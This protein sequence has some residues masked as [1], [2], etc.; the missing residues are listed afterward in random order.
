[1]Q[2]DYVILGAL[3][4]GRY[5]G[6][7]LRRWMEGSGRYIGYGVQLPQIYRRL[8]VLVDRGLVEFEVDPREG[9]PDAKVYSLTE[10]GRAALLEWARS[11]FEPSPR[12][13]D[14]DFKLRFYFAGQLDREIAIDIVRTELEYRLKH[15]NLTAEAPS[16]TGYEA[17][18]PDLDPEWARQIHIM[19]HEHGYA[20]TAAYIA[21]LQLTLARLERGGAH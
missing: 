9:R 18:I 15:D 19:G 12:P 8:G 21:W 13:M 2:L 1:M 7:D 6:Y 3:A 5:S 20:S 17:Q 11:P 14:P 4:L 10:A 16:P